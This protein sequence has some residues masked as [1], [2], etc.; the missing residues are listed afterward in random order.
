MPSFVSDKQ[1]HPFRAAV[2][3]LFQRKRPEPS[4]PRLPQV[5]GNGQT[6]VPGVY[7]VGEIAG[8]PL[9]KL[10]VNAG[11][12]LTHRLARELKAKG[13]CPEGALDLVIIGAGSSGLGAAVAAQDLG[14]SAVVL[15]ANHLAET[16]YTMT[17][18]KLIF[19]EPE[20]V[21]KKGRIWFEECTREELLQRWEAQV[22]D[23]GLDVRTFEKVE[24]VQRQGD[25][26]LVTS[27]KGEY[28]ARRVVLAA[29]KAGNPRKAGVPGE[30]EHGHKI[31]HRLID[32][33]KHRD[34]DI[35]IYGGG[36]VALEAALSLCDRNRV[37]LVTIDPEFTYPKKRNIDAV[38]GKVAAGK[39]DL[40]FGS[41]LKSI[42]A[43]TITFSVGG[44]AGEI[45][46]I[47]NDHVFEMIGAELPFGFFKKVGIRLEQTWQWKRW[48]VLLLAFLGVYSLYSIKSF[49]KGAVAWPFEGMISPAAYDGTL[50]AMFE[51]GFLPF[52]WMFQ[53]AA[54]ADIMADRGF[55]QGYL[56]SL[57][58][59]IVMVV[60]GWEAMIRWR[61]HARDGRYQT[62]RYL[63]LLAFQVGFFLIVNV[64]AVQA[65][66]VTYAWRAWG[67]YQPFP[68]F[69]NTFFWWDTGPNGDPG[70][71]MAFFII[72]GLLGT[73]VLIPLLAW[74]HGKRFCT[75]VCG[76]GGLAETLGDR[77]RH[78]SPKGERSRAWE[79][80][81]TAIMLAAFM[82]GV[83]I[84][85]AYNT[86]GSNGWWTAYA[87]LVDFWLVAVIP[88][89]LYPF[90]GGKVWC[91]YWCP[92]AA[93]NQVLSRWYG[94]LKIKSNDKCISCTECS[95][96]CQVGVDV[97]AFAKNQ[98]SFDNK[99]SSCIHC[100]IC[101]DV[102][103]MGVLS[104]STEKRSATK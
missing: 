33:D 49:G 37:T 75:W 5:D 21:E 29:G 15:E 99:N 19:A 23:F 54:L 84:V 72:A 4:Y 41:F 53:E 17:K 51:W 66:S 63:T 52:A 8:T 78:L 86:S 12:D 11:H 89:T 100:G 102:C 68:L 43:D 76:C 50:R 85:T 46:E 92:L 80:Q 90:F 31:D 48:V 14:L 45:R 81:A 91:R 87:Y 32:P 55:Q 22:R 64:I 47:K 65:L 59:T 67:L 77:W 69:F 70:S 74:K 30:V 97:M 61:G 96:Y 35:F 24:D 1:V 103:P 93:W 40:H 34:Q 13:P 38:M 36:D 42:A 79:W 18:G 60:F 58:Y 39:I 71:V 20:D 28:R 10:G 56:Y 82:I 25:L 98:E 62:Y 73:F 6:T 101:I 95:K 16:V 26:L 7:A 27:T 57:L 88:I 3:Q 44:S 9:I 104:F 2:S 94:R 83:I